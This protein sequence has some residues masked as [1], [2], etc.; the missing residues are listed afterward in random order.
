MNAPGITK[1]ELKRKLDNEE[2]ITIL[3]VRNGVD[4]G[5]SGVKVAGALRMPLEELEARAGELDPGK[6]AVAYC[7]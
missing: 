4:Y 3:D 2:D 7:T 6:E 5:N 1:E